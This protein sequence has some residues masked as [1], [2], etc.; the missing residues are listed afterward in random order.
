LGVLTVS[1]LS[2]SGQCKEAASKANRVFGMVSRQFWEREPWSFL[3]VYK[4]FVRRHL[5]YAIQAWPP[6]LRRDINCSEKIQR[7]ATKMVKGFH[8]LPYE[9]RLKKLKLTTLLKGDYKEIS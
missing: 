2:V 7:R 6:Y 1:D 8:K 5:E 4:G 3:I 9:P